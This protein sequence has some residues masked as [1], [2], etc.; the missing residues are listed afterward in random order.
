MITR[1]RAATLASLVFTALFLV[2]TAGPAAAY[3]FPST[4]DANRE[5]GL[6]HVNLVSTGPETVTLEFVNTTNSL[7]FFEYR[8][9]GETVGNEDMSRLMQDPA[10]L[11]EVLSGQS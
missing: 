5:A 7:A 2:V 4:N 6:P 3:D 11:D 10:H 8:I 9:D 1:T